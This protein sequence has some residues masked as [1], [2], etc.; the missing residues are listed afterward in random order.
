MCALDM[1][2]LLYVVRVECEFEK[3]GF[4]YFHN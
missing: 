1:D 4:I 3:F 2:N